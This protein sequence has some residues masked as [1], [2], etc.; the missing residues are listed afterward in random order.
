MTNH[1][2]HQVPAAQS[3]PAPRRAPDDD[4][5]DDLTAVVLAAYLAE[6]RTGARIQTADTPLT[7]GGT[8]T[9]G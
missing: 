6:L 4:T 3:R 9:A 1:R 7:A 5:L 2:E 8:A